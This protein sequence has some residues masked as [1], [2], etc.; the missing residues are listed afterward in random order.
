M[1]TRFRKIVEL[2]SSHK[3]EFIVVGGLA[4]IVHGSPRL[5]Q[6][7]DVVYSRSAE[8]LQRIVDALRPHE[9]YLRGAP[10]GLPFLWDARTLKN[11]LNFTLRTTLGDID[12]LGEITGGGGYENLL[13]HSQELPMFGVRARVLDLD[14]LIEVK[15]AAGRPK[16]FETIAELEAIREELKGQ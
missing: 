16:D 13:P 2:L 3:I 10:P 8:N 12:L 1:I 7:V 5:T 4:A 14:K 6:D 9:P 11:G 15:R